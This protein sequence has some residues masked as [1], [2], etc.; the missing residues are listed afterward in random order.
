MKFHHIRNATCIIETAEHR[1]LIDP[2]LSASGELPPFSFFRFPRKANPIVEL[3]AHTDALLKDITHCL[4]THSQTFNFRPLQHSDH[5]DHRGEEFLIRNN[6]GI[7][8]R[9][10]DGKY[11]QKYGMR[12][13]HQLEYWQPHP[14][15]GAKIT[16]VPAKHG[17][18][19]NHHLMANGAGFFL[20]LPGEPTIY[21]AGDTVL[22]AN[23]EKALGHFKP[24]IAVAAAGSAQ[25]DIGPPILMSVEELVAFAKKAPG[26]VIFNHLEALNHCPTTRVQLRTVLEEHRLLSRSMIPEDGESLVLE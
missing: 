13:E 3:P 6:I 2:M 4:I 1:I 21:I 23:V 17:H 22:T 10:Q 24:D 20:E 5:L 12:V 9:K 7:T 25:L 16:A 14:F 19:W 8:T 18:G 11:L 26:K 15:G